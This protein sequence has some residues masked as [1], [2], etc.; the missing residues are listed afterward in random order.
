MLAG[1]VRSLHETIV[2]AGIAD[3]AEI[4]LDTLEERIAAEVR[5]ANAAFLAAHRRLRLGPQDLTSIAQCSSAS[6]PGRFPGV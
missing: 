2:G 3:S 6:I 4:G 5:E 1:V